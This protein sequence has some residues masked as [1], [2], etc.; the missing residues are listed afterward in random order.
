MQTPHVSR[1]HAHPHALPHFYPHTP[2]DR[3]NGIL[4]RV[5]HQQAIIYY[6]VLDISLE[7]LEKLKTLRVRPGL[8]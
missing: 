3:W 2:C 4:D 5:L 8:V 6:E 7:E 1:T